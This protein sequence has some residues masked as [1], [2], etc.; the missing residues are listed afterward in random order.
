MVPP[1]RGAEE[2]CLPLTHDPPLLVGSRSPSPRLDDPGVRVEPPLPHRDWDQDSGPA[3]R[4]TDETGRSAWGRGGS[5]FPGVSHPWG[6]IRPLGGGCFLGPGVEPLSYVS[7]AHPS[8]PWR[9][10]SGVPPPSSLVSTPAV[11]RVLEGVKEEQIDDTL[12]K[13]TSC[14]SKS[15]KTFQCVE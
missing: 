1:K 14:L 12:I 11:G 6:R 13:Y 8:F 10:G 15:M 9:V 7:F 2:V 3:G 5:G 4:G